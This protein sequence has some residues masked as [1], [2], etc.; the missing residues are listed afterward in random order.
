MVLL[1]DHGRDIRF[2]ST[3]SKSDDDH[4]YDET[5]EGGVGK[6]GG[7]DGGEDE[8]EDADH[9]DSA[10]NTDGLVFAQ[11]LIG[12]DRSQDWGHIAED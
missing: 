8:D 4:G 2:D 6:D 7:G 10:E 1:C 5:W 3:S 11:V 9:V 12:D